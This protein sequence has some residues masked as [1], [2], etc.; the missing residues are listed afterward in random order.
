MNAHICV[1]V[2]VWAYIQSCVCVC[3]SGGY[4]WFLRV[5]TTESLS[6]MKTTLRPFRKPT[7]FHLEIWCNIFFTDF[8]QGIPKWFCSDSSRH[9]KMVGSRA[10]SCGNGP[11]VHH[12]AGGSSYSLAVPRAS[13][14][15]KRNVTTLQFGLSLVPQLTLLHSLSYYVIV[16][17]L[18]WV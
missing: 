7:R 14:L 16:L 10:R 8:S 15:L 5:Y 4:N 2:C 6:I 17:A 12:K 3:I 11:P 18:L 13:P 9:S 1:W